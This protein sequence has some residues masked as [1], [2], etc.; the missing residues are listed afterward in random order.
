MIMK[1]YFRIRDDVINVFKFDKIS[2]HGIFLP[3]FSIIIIWKNSLFY[4]VFSQALP[5]LIGYHGNNEWPMLKLLIFKDDLYIGLKSH[6]VSWRLAKLFLRYSAKILRGHVVASPP[7][8][9]QKV[10]NIFP[11]IYS[12]SQ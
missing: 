11:H 8:P 2:T 7:P 12:H 5:P 1:S 3:S 4:H 6:K 10:L 9:V